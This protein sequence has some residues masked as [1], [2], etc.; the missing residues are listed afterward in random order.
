[1]AEKKKSFHT[2]AS[3]SGVLRGDNISII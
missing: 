2:K 3:G 1:M